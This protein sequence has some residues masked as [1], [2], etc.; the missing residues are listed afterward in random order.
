MVIMLCCHNVSLSFDTT[1]EAYDIPKV[2]LTIYNA[3]K[4][5][6]YKMKHICPENK[7]G[8]PCLGAEPERR[9]KIKFVYVP[10][11]NLGKN[12][13]PPADGGT[14]MTNYFGIVIVRRIYLWYDSHQ[15]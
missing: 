8:H 1:N 12:W 4:V 9:M 15:L 6:L 2:Y 14:G 10:K 13:I 7:L 5:K 3:L 11:Y